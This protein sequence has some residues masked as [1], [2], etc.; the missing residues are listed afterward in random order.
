MQVYSILFFSS[1]WKQGS[2]G[3]HRSGI[4]TSKYFPDCRKWPRLLFKHSLSVQTGLR[5][6]DGRRY[7]ISASLFCYAHKRS[8]PKSTPGF[9]TLEMSFVEITANLTT[10]RCVTRGV[11]SL[12]TRRFLFPTNKGEKLLLLCPSY[13]WYYQIEVRGWPCSPKAALVHINSK[14]STTFTRSWASLYES[15]A[16]TAM[17]GTPLGK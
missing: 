1:K 10:G 17:F 16:P 13:H 4:Q 11:W 8:K 12:V 3:A 5:A 15:K 6:S 9:L 14:T 7:F 2:R